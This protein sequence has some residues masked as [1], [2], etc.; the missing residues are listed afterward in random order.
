MIR[1]KKV[2]RNKYGEWKHPEMPN[3]EESISKEEIRQFE[4]KNHIDLHFVFF[5]EEAPESLRDDYYNKGYESSRVI[6]KWNPNCSIS[7]SFLLSI[8][9]TEEGPIAIFAI[10]RK[11]RFYI[12][13]KNNF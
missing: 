3:W 6:K 4:N 1:R 13:I 8:H 12:D 7:P 9:E 11:E 10:E 5:E 2:I